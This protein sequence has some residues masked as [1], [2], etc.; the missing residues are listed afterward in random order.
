MKPVAFL[1]P[2]SMRNSRAAH[3]ATTGGLV[4]MGMCD[5]DISRTLFIRSSDNKTKYSLLST[6]VYS[7][8]WPK[9]FGVHP[10]PFSLLNFAPLAPELVF[11]NLFEVAGYR[12]LWNWKFVLGCSVRLQILS[13]E[14]RL[15]R[16]LP[17]CSGKG[18]RRWSSLP[19]ENR[20]FECD[21]QVWPTNT[22]LSWTKWPR[23]PY[24]EHWSIPCVK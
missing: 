10:A 18:R 13:P 21:G 2:R 11:E 23:R 19:V 4:A 20:M 7:C 17:V 1:P 16:M 15:L 22:V 8:F 3:Q 9:F 14:L 24:A 5:V 12:R 6:E